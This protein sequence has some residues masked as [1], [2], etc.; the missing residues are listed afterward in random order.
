MSFRPLRLGLSFGHGGP[1]H[2][3]GCGAG[4][5]CDSCGTKAGASNGVVESDYVRELGE[6]FYAVIPHDLVSVIRLNEPHEN[7]HTSDR[8]RRARDA[9]SDIVFD[10]HVNESANDMTHGAHMFYRP[11]CRTSMLVAREIARG[12]PALLR[13]DLMGTV[14]Q[15]TYI[16]GMVEPVDEGLYPRAA[17]LLR[18]Y[19]PMPCVLIEAFYASNTGDCRAALDPWAQTCMVSAML[20][21]VS[22]AGQA[23]A[24]LRAS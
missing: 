13:R 22:S 9:G 19:A 6:E 15:G 1:H 7:V 3:E 24:P 4:A 16:A 20:R 14:R 11:E 17:W 10:L 18:Q 12:W 21:G 8:A 5:D 23:L 2:N